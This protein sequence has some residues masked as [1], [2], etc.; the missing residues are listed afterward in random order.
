MSLIVIFCVA[1]MRA[2]FCRSV[3]DRQV[4]LKQC[5]GGSVATGQFT[6]N[7]TRGQSSHGLVT[8]G[9]VNAPESLV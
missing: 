3:V 8:R 2:L 4:V 5:S 6:D 9:E 7:P 1:S